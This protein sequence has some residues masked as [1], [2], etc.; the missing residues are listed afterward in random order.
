MK[1]LRK[2][3]CVIEEGFTELFF[4]R[5]AWELVDSNDSRLQFSPV[6]LTLVIGTRAR[7]M[8]MTVMADQQVLR[9]FGL[10]DR[11]PRQ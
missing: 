10:G 9:R 3:R 6:V 2:P 11:F 4:K 7:D 8:A 1:R 5:A